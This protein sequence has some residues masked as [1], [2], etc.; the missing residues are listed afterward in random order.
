MYDFL[1]V[2]DSPEK[3]L[4]AVATVLIVVGILAPTKLPVIGPVDW[5]TTKR[6]LLGL[7][8]VLFLGGDVLLA[9]SSG[10]FFDKR[11]PP[12]SP[13]SEPG[14]PVCEVLRSSNSAEEQEINFK[15]DRDQPVKL[16]WVT[17]KCELTGYGDIPPSTRLP[18]TTY[19]GHVWLV[20]DLNDQPIAIFTAIEPGLTATIK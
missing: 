1:K 7:I 17:D 14:R 2:F 16:Y 19:K 4:V 13:T 10:G 18:I 5:T 6:N 9:M 12:A 11:L 8:G 20:T 3:I 15:N